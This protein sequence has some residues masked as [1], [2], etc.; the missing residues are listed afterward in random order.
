MADADF[1]DG[2]RSQPLGD[3]KAGKSS[4][5]DALAAYVA[6]LN[7]FDASPFRGADGALTTE[8]VAGRAVFDTLNCQQCHGGASFSASGTPNLLDVGT[9][10]QPTSGTRLGGALTGIDPPTLRDVWATAPY[11]HDGSAATLEQAVLA[12]AGVT[13]GADDLAKLVAYLKQIDGSEPTPVVPPPPPPDTTAPTKPPSLSISTVNG[14]PRLTWGASSDNVAV[15]G[16]RV[17][18]SQDGTFGPTIA[19]VTGGALT[20][21]DATATEGVYYTYA[22]VAY[23]AAGNTSARSVFRRVTAGAA[24][25]EPSGL[26]AVVSPGQVVLSW[27]PSTDNVGVTAYIVY[28]ST[29]NAVGPEVGR[30]DGAVTTWTDTTGVPG[31]KYT[32]SVKATDAAGYLSGRSNFRTVTVQ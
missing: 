11:L 22:V 13:P 23:D 25:T 3:S 14:F 15:A 10:R 24:P 18:R 6:S 28:R 32:Y 12:H 29:K 16:Y 21:G 27:S 9:I 31:T 1:N 17:H 8:G 4:D 2:T 19:S 20:W 30:T 5:L 7:V 26:T